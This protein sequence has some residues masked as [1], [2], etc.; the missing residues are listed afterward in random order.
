[1]VKTVKPMTDGSI[2]K[3]MTFFALPLMLGNLFQQMYNTVDS[4]IVGNFF[5]KQR[6][7]CCQLVGQPDFYADWFFKRY[8]FWSRSDCCQIFWRPGQ[9]KFTSYR[10]HYSGFWIGGWRGDDSGRHDFFAPDFDLDGDA[11]KCYGEFRC[12]FAN[13]FFRLAG[14]CYV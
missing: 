8:F 7:G 5:G 9:G 12:L 4:L 14:I 3:Q 11:G 2:W 6:F 1:M 13:L 10:S